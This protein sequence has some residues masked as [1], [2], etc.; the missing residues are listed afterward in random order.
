MILKLKKKNYIKVN[1]YIKVLSIKIN[2]KILL[3]IKR[4]IINY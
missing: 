1:L 3:I 2:K 4:F